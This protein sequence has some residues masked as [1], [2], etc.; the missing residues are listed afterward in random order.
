MSLLNLPVSLLTIIILYFSDL[1]RS[2]MTFQVLVANSLHQS[3]T[4]GL[5]PHA[6]VNRIWPSNQDPSQLRFLNLTLSLVPTT[7]PGRWALT[8][9]VGHR[10]LSLLER[11]AQS[12]QCFHILC[13][14][15]KVLPFGKSILL[16]VIFIFI[17]LFN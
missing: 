13:Q 10:P 11:C 2:G 15:L 16:L 8:E 1:K 3:K 4:G 9:D 6:H 5:L 17:F 7:F 12:T 14:C